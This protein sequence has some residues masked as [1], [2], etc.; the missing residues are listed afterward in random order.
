MQDGGLGR[1]FAQNHY[2]SRTVVLLL[3]SAIASFAIVFV[4]DDSV[5]QKRFKLYL[6]IA[7]LVVAACL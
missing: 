2:N 4:R 6:L 1:Q 7:G 3:G 5:D